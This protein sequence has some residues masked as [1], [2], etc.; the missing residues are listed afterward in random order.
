MNA[1][2][3]GL[4]GGAPV[5]RRGTTYVVEFERS[6][7][8]FIRTLLLLCGQACA[9]QHAAAATQPRQP[10]PVAMI[11]YSSPL[12]G[13]SPAAPPPPLPLAAAAPAAAAAAAAA[14]AVA[15]SDAAAPP[16][17][18]AAAAAVAA[19]AGSG[20]CPGQRW[21]VR[22]QISATVVPLYWSPYSAPSAY[23][24]YSTAATYMHPYMQE[25]RRRTRTHSS[26]NAV[27]SHIVW[28]E[29][30]RETGR[31]RSLS[32]QPDW[33]DG[34]DLLARSVARSVARTEEF[35]QV[36]VAAREEQIGSAVRTLDQHTLPVAA[37]VL[38]R[39]R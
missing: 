33:R 20:S 2:S 12:G 9:W 36:R 31:D 32:R 11:G 16:A 29:T 27:Q 24:T 7:F 34:R 19:A 23:Y 26:S 30:G 13:S 39:W 1:A 25:R 10:F 18:A 3:L 5:A 22:G 6:F 15:A 35:M 14:A 17:G 37:V 38:T 8:C 4:A 28:R 21:H